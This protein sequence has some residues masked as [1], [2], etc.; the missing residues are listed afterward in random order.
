M[1]SREEV[2]ALKEGD[3]LWDKM[4]RDHNGNPLKW[5]VVGELKPSR[6][7]PESFLRQIELILELSDE[8]I[9]KLKLEVPR[10]EHDILE[11]LKE[12]KGY[13]VLNEDSMY[14]YT[15]DETIARLT[16]VL[17]DMEDGITPELKEEFQKLSSKILS[18][19]S[20]KERLERLDLI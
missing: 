10:E 13:K 8:E 19:R 12:L 9:E 3:I 4:T 16:F 20:A 14:D 17:W 5:K 11:N 6:H 1:K 18:R 2:Q 15:T 7:N